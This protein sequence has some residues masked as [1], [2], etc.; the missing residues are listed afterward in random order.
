LKLKHDEPLSKFAFDFNLCRCSEVAAWL[1]MVLS[2]AGDEYSCDAAAATVLSARVTGGVLL[3]MLTPAC[4]AAVLPDLPPAGPHPHSPFSSTGLLYICVS[5]LK[6]NKSNDQKATVTPHLDPQREPNS[7]GDDETPL[8]LVSWG[9]C[10]RF[11]RGL[12]DCLLIRIKPGWKWG[13]CE[14]VHWLAHCEQTV[15]ERVSR[16]GRRI[17][18]ACPGT[19]L[20]SFQTFRDRT[21]GPKP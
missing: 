15:W 16:S 2:D 10:C 21:R 11:R 1:R 8:N 5:V 7:S 20:H 3:T 13:E 19:L 18:R 6:Q 9:R 12:S 14:R 4:V 17:R